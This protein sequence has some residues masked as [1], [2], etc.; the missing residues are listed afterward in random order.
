VFRE[1]DLLEEKYNITY[2]HNEVDF[3]VDP[4]GVL[5]NTNTQNIKLEIEKLVK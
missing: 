2:T 5:Y 1:A 3:L 4:N